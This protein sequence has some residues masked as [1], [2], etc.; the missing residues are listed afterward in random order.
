CKAANNILFDHLVGA[1]KHAR[2][3]IESE[4]PRGLEVDHQLVLG[5]RLNRQLGWLLAFQDAVDVAGGAPELIDEIR[6]IGH[7]AAGVD[8]DTIVVD[9]GQLVAGRQLDDQVAMKPYRPPPV[10]IRPPFGVRAKAATAR[11]ISAAPLTLTGLTSTRS[12][13][14]TAW[15][16]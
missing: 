5:R 9:R 1:G 6:A 8:E 10:T 3:Q 15:M 4:R 7:Q 12:D 2:R 14:A 11:S 13:G 16:T